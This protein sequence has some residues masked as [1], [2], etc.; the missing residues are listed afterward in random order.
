MKVG[1]FDNAA[2]TY[3][4]PDG[5]YHY[6]TDFMLQDGVNV[7]RENNRFSH[8][9]TELVCKTRRL[10]LSFMNA[11]ETR[12]VIFCP[13]ATIALNTILFG[14]QLK[15]GDNVYISHFEHNAVLRVLYQIQNTVSINIK[16]LPMSKSQIFDFDLGEMKKSF[17]EYSPKL[18]IASQVSNVVGN[19]APIETITKLAKHYN[20]ITVI[21]GAQACG[22]IDL[23]LINVDYYVFAGHKTLLGPTGIGG[24]ICDK[25]ARLK[26]YIFGGTGVDSSNMEMPLEIP[27]RFEA[28]SLNLM[29]IAGLYFSLNWIKENKSDMRNLEKDNYEKLYKLLSNYEFIHII[30]PRN[31]SSIVACKFDGYTSDEIGRVLSER[32]IAVRTGLHCAPETHKYL[33]THPEGLVRFSVSCMTNEGDFHVLQETLDILAEEL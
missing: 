6:M 11:P 1:Y 15:D 18:V 27:T 21:D 14:L 12:E 20:A 3:K 9:A 30:S 17:D 33:N 16:Y 7:G 29:A 5:M 22:L 4:K 19:I 2:T 24:F 28:G 26:P 23:D 13:S 10:L 31:A 25:H 8:D 32:G